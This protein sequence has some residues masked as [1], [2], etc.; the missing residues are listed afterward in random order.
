MYRNQDFD[1]KM[2][3]TG[4]KDVAAVI[5]G[6]SEPF[7][8]LEAKRYVIIEYEKQVNQAGYKGI[9]TRRIHR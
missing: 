9:Y 1:I 4:R 5:R 7:N 8:L 6:D 3:D 2:E